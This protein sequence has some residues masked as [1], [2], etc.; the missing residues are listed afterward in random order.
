MKKE[1]SWQ[2]M[3]NT[4]D[5]A[6]AEWITILEKMLEIS[7]NLLDSAKR[8]QVVLASD[9]FD[10]LQELLQEEEA[11]TASLE[12]VE[13]QRLDFQRTYKTRPATLRGQ[14]TVLPA[15][16]KG[17]ATELARDLVRTV[18]ALALQNKINT[19]IIQ[20][21]LNFAGYN[22]DQLY[23]MTSGPAYGSRGDV[24]PS[25]AGRAIVDRKI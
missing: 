17:Q 12:K 9:N 2:K 3:T 11:M 7:G 22:L 4:A 24:S 21:L 20:H 5:S 6:T 16:E 19:E 10:D 8:K 23:K 1:G 18:E 14:M 25:V 15:P 13:K